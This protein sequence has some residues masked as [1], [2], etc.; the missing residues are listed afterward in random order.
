MTEGATQRKPRRSRPAETERVASATSAPAPARQQILDAHLRTHI[1]P[2]RRHQMIA[3]AAYY[4][5]QQRLFESGY[6]LED[7]LAAEDQIDAALRLADLETAALL[8]EKGR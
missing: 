4:R 8:R 2:E 1:D 5:A 3:E 7:W 6:E